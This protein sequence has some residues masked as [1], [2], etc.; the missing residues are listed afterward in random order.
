M[1]YALRRRMLF[2]WES[3]Q[4]QR[5]IHAFGASNNLCVKGPGTNY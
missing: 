4:R 1:L 2:N 5:A 3:N